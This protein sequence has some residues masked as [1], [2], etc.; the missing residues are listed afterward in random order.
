MLKTKIKFVFIGVKPERQT[1]IKE[2]TEK[3]LKGIKRINFKKIKKAEAHIASIVC[4]NDES[5]ETITFQI[6]FIG[7]TFHI[8]S[9][10]M[11]IEENSE[12]IIEDLKA[13]N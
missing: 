1:K 5:K 7:R 10:A 12:I 11:D 2:L 3:T 4:F 6:N 13:L 9:I 8:F